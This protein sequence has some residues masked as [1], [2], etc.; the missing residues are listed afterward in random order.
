MSSKCETRLS[1]PSLFPNY[2]GIKGWTEG[3]VASQT[4]PSAQLPHT[5]DLHVLLERIP[6]CT[7]Y[8]SLSHFMEEESIFNYLPKG[9]K[10]QGSEVG[11]KSRTPGSFST[12]TLLTR[13][14]T[15]D[16]V[17]MRSRNLVRWHIA[18]ACL[19]QPASI[20]CPKGWHTHRGS[21]CGLNDRTP[22]E[23]G[24]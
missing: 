10:C 5:W 22:G 1:M 13:N 17:P 24:V 15:R 20:V 12:R 7:G 9:L 11:L 4:S 8:R 23:Q 3:G 14:K 6:L 18:C 2:K 21:A 16:G 19:H